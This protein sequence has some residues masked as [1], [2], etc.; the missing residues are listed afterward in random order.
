MAVEDG[1][2]YAR[3]PK[4]AGVDLTGQEQK[5]VD[6][7][8]SGQLVL[9]GAGVTVGVLEHGTAV[10]KSSTYRVRGLTAVLC[11]GTIAIKGPFTSNASGLAVAATTGTNALG[12]LEEAGASGKVAQAFIDPYR[13]P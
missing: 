1:D 10:G 3:R 13:V 8:A 2:I 7:N 12:Y 5:L 11:G 6:I 9:A 4:V